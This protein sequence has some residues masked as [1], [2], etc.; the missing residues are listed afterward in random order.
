ML[1][2]RLSEGFSLKEYYERYGISFLDGKELVIDQFVNAGLISLSDDRISLT[3]K[4]FY[5]SN[6]IL[7]EIL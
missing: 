6:S 5:L 7:I 3:E 4:G 1:A 2:L